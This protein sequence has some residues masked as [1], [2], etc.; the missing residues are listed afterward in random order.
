MWHVPSTVTLWILK[1][2]SVAVVDIIIIII[3][4]VLVKNYLLQ[5]N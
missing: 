3:T 1:M 4:V 2:A 5:E